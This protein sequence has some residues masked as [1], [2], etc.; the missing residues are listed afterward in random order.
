MCLRHPW[1]LKYQDDKNNSTTDSPTTTTTPRIDNNNYKTNE[2]SYDNSKQHTCPVP[3][4]P[5][6]NSTAVPQFQPRGEPSIRD[7]CEI[8]THTNSVNHLDLPNNLELPIYG[9][10][11]ASSSHDQNANGEVNGEVREETNGHRK[12]PIHEGVT[13]SPMP[14]P[15]GSRRALSLNKENLPKEVQEAKRFCMQMSPQHQSEV[16]C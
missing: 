5:N 14:S 11:Q 3:V 9:D 16:V 1:I 4:S 12:E 15:L 8:E 2:L 10:G 7:D 6:N 13:R